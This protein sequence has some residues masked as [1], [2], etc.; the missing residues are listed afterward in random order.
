MR[1]VV[2]SSGWDC[3]FPGRRRSSKTV[4][5]RLRVNLEGS[6]RVCGFLVEFWMVEEVFAILLEVRCKA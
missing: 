3:I 5:G 2:L 1:R 4:D 6:I